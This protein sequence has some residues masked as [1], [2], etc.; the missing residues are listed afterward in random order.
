MYL[1]LFVREVFI[2]SGIDDICMM[3]VILVYVLVSVSSMDW[4][5]R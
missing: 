3:G 5:Q 2:E 1:V 4:Y